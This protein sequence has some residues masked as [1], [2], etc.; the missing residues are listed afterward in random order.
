[1]EDGRT[2]VE[3]FLTDPTSAY[4]MR[5]TLHPGPTIQDPPYHWHKYQTETFTVESGI[6]LATVE[7][8]D[9]AIT[10]GRT[11][12]IRPGIYHTFKNGS[13]DTDLVVCAGLDPQER[14]RDEAFFRNLYCYLDDCR[15]AGMSPSPFQMCLW[16]YCFDCYLALPGPRPLAKWFSERLVWTMGVMIGK[17][18]LGMRESYPEYFEGD[19]KTVLQRKNTAEKKP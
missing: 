14:E 7:G 2:H 9:E 6:F 15:K 19:I 16:L 5:S 4:A 12:T 11:V 18:L 1:M 8:K 17:W 10:A 13:P 3:F